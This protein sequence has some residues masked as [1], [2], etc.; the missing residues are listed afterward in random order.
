MMK[1]LGRIVELVRYLVKS[2]AGIGRAVELDLDRR[3][4]RANIVLETV[5]SE[6]FLED[7]WIG[8]MLVFG[9]RDPGPA[10]S[11]TLC[12]ERCRMINLDPQTAEQDTRV[13]QTVVRL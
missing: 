5:C 7:G 3:R 9:D 13:M 8:R 2:M 1:P 12:D 10:V 4:F 6:P 11:V